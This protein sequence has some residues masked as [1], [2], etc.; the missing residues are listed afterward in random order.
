MN[1]FSISKLSNLVQGNGHEII[2]IF[3]Y[4]QHVRY[5]I[6]FCKRF[7]QF[8]GMEIHN[9]PITYQSDKLSTP[10]HFYGLYQSDKPILKSLNTYN[11]S[12]ID[13]E[14]AIKRMYQKERLTTLLKH[15]FFTMMWF[16]DGKLCHDK[17]YFQIENFKHVEN[18]MIWC[19][20]LDDYYIH[21]SKISV[22]VHERYSKVFD[23][24]TKNI[25]SQFESLQ[26]M[27]TYTAQLHDSLQEFKN[28]VSKFESQFHT[29][30]AIFHR[31][32]NSPEIC[33]KVIELTYQL[34]RKQSEFLLNHEDVF[35]SLLFH[36]SNIKEILKLS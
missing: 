10:H 5:L 34:F 32:Q 13:T 7:R 17:Y 15:Q 16:V 4:K 24:I 9:I 27:L 22:L 35:F 29:I 25:H 30:S 1:S 19:I 33:F 14:V 11:T 20:S 21:Q 3:V 2:E 26:K 18:S 12:N 8:F 23:F 28:K 31:S 6:L 36:T